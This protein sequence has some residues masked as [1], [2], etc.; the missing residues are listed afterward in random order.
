MHRRD[1]FPDHHARLMRRV[2]VNFPAD[3]RVPF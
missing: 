2:G 3:L 1:P